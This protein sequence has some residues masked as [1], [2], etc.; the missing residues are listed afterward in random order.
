MDEKFIETRLLI[1]T[2]TNK[3][4]FKTFLPQKSI[5]ENVLTLKIPQN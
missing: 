1:C 2:Y 4:I 5:S 3:R